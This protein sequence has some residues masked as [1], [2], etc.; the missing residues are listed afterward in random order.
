MSVNSV[1]VT[2]YTFVGVKT[3]LKTCH[4]PEGLHNTIIFKCPVRTWRFM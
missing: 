3:E 4:M 2:V 1:V